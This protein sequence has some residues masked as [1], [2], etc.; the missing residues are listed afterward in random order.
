MVS[1]PDVRANWQETAKQITAR[2]KPDQLA[3]FRRLDLEIQRVFYDGLL[4]PYLIHVAIDKP[5]YLLKPLDM[6]SAL[7]QSQIDRLAFELERIKRVALAFGAA[8]IVVPVPFME[9]VF[10]ALVVFAQDFMCR[11]LHLRMTL[12]VELTPAEASRAE[13][14]AGRDGAQFIKWEWTMNGEPVRGM[15]S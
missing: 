12:P 10:A 8:V 6:T 7:T 14:F 3:Q 11:A 2:M 1:K 13:A 4:N 15:S 9:T 5:D